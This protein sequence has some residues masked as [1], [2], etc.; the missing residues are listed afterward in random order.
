[1]EQLQ[2]EMGAEQGTKSPSALPGISCC[3]VARL[4]RH[5]LLVVANDTLVVADVNLVVAVAGGCEETCRQLASM[6][7][8]DPC[9]SEPWQV[10]VAVNQVGT[11]CCIPSARRAAHHSCTLGSYSKHS[12]AH[13]MTATL[14][15]VLLVYTVDGACHDGY[16]Q[17]MP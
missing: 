8:T 11:H 17:K 15:V 3:S 13:L 1:M 9:I 4:W 2:E 7:L 5:Q 14:D 12:I 10:H 6:L 16:N